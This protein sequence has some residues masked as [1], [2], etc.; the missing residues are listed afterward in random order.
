MWRILLFPLHDKT[1]SNLS[2]VAASSQSLIWFTAFEVWHNSLSFKGQYSLIHLL[3]F[4]QKKPNIILQYNYSWIYCVLHIVI[5]SH[6]Y[7]YLYLWFFLCKRCSYTAETQSWDLFM[8]MCT[9]KQTSWNLYS[10]DFTIF[11]KYL[12]LLFEIYLGQH[13]E[14]PVVDS[15]VW[16]IW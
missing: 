2:T 9:G 8:C 12:L 11:S 15:E 16:C 6:Y 10:R 1:L 13:Q 3:F 4:P 14:A 7:F 5:H